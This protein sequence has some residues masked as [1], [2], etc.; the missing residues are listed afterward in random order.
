MAKYWYRIDTDDDGNR[1]LCG[2]TEF[3]LNEMMNQLSTQ[4]H[5]RLDDMFYRDSQNQLRAWGDWEPRLEPTAIIR[6]S[7]IRTVMPFK[8]TPPIVT[9]GGAHES[10]QIR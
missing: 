4:T 8:G 10:H 6:C 1:G 9:Q 7:A 3:D 2:S 5:I